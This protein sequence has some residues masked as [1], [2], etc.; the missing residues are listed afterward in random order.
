MSGFCIKKDSLN[1]LKKLSQNNNRDWFNSH[2][3]RYL[4]AHSNIADF[5]DALLAEMNKHDHVETPSGKKSIFRIYKDVRFAKDKTPYNTHWSGR[6]K[7]ATKKLRGGYYFRIE[8]GN[9]WL[10]GGF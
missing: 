1:F 3:E 9:S 4:E 8:P 5:A 2:K 6:F 7:R 10:F